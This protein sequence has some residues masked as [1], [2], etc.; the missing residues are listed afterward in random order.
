MKGWSPFT[1]KGILGKIHEKLQ[2]I[3]DP[4]ASY[5]AE[6]KFRKKPY[7]AGE[8]P[9]V[10]KIIEGYKKEGRKYPWTDPK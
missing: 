6:R 9:E 8:H 1:Q 5:K 10:T 2:S 3:K 4:L 7:P